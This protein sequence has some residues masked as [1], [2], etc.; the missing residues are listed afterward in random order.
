MTVFLHIGVLYS[1]I[2]RYPGTPSLGKT[3]WH[4]FLNRWRDI[5]F[6]TDGG[7]LLSG[8]TE[9]QCL[10][11]GWRDKSLRRY[12]AQQSPGPTEGHRTLD[13]CRDTVIWTEKGTPSP[14]RTEEHRLLDETERHPLLNGDRDTVSWK[15]GCCFHK[16]LKLW[17]TNV[18]RAT[19]TIRANNPSAPLLQTQ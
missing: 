6:R 7:K 4:R 12:G 18:K 17:P 9:R 1:W 13:G 11:D 5:V 10:L 14:R 15:K 8:R 16:L 19:W 2:S 3:E